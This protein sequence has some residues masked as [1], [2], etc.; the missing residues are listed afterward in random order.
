M[1]FQNERAACSER[2]K[3]LEQG[4]RE[5]VGKVSDLVEYEVYVAARDI[6]T[7]EVPDGAVADGFHVL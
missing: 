7:D 4:T 2:G 1:D 5:G 3:G 6:G